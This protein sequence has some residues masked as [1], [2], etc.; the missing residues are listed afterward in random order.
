[1]WETVAA[2]RG[3][4]ADDPA[5]LTDEQWE[6]PSLNAEWTV[7]HTLAHMV[8]TAHTGPLG[9]GVGIV[10]SGFRFSE[11]A[12]RGIIKHI[13]F[14]PAETL[15]SFRAI[16][17]SKKAPPDRRPPGWARRSSTPR[18]SVVRSASPTT[19]PPRRWRRASSSSKGPTP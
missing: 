19:T 17:H 3:A 5:G 15:A 10:R 6:T 11:F 16:Q 8:S 1:M 12:D 4:L 13:G 18:T 14:T 7:H 2:E 9:F